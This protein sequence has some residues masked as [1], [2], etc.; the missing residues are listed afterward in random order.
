MGGFSILYY[1]VYAFILALKRLKEV[2]NGVF[3]ILSHLIDIRNYS[4]N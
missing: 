3:L 2:W 4:N 1:V